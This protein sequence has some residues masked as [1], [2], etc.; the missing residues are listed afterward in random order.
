[1]SSRRQ[2]FVNSAVT[3]GLLAGGLQFLV[4]VAATQNRYGDA[5]QWLAFRR[6]MFIAVA[7]PALSW[8][9]TAICRGLM[10]FGFDPDDATLDGWT[11]AIIIIWPLLFAPVAFLS[12]VAGVLK[13]LPW[14]F[15][16]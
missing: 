3:A 12:I 8:F 16:D 13:L 15:D 6:G 10:K 1:M 2:A 9:A 4:T 14:G 7:Y 5:D 11:H